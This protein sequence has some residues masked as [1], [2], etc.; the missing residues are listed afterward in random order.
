MTKP[1]QLLLDQ[2]DPRVS[3][4]NPSKLPEWENHSSDLFTRNY[5]QNYTTASH[6][7]LSEGTRGIDLLSRQLLRTGGGVTRL[8]KSQHGLCMTTFLYISP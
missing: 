1:R 5:I 6:C 4:C 2:R 3:T 8:T 7:H